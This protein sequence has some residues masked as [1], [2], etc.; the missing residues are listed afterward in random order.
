MRP[1]STDSLVEIDFQRLAAPS[2]STKLTPGD[3]G[4]IAW[5]KFNNFMD[6]EIPGRG[7]QP[8]FIAST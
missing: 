3:F 1:T 8:I 4:S 2:V 7:L 6:Q 5:N